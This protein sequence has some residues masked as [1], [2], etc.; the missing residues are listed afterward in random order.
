[1]PGHLKQGFFAGQSRLWC[2]S[3]RTKGRRVACEHLSHIL[4][5]QDVIVPWPPQSLLVEVQSPLENLQHLPFSCNAD[6]IFYT[7]RY[8]E[9]PFFSSLTIPA[10]SSALRASKSYLLLSVAL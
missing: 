6:W 10:A 8:G 2:A 7:S 5:Q 9:M 4:L 3:A 1:M